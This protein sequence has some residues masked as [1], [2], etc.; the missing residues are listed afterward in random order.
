[1]IT[2]I[3]S[4][5]EN[6]LIGKS[7]GSMPWHEPEDLKWFKQTTMGFPIIMGRKTWE[8]LPK[9]PLPGR[10]NIVVS[11]SLPCQELGDHAFVPSIELA[12]G[13]AWVKSKNWPQAYDQIFVI[14]GAEIYKYVIEKNMVDEIIVSKIRGKHEGDIYFPKID[15]NIWSY[16]PFKRFD[17]FEV[18]KYMRM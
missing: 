18:L 14:G 4:T 15:E 11:R 17:N 16:M 1:M 7:D 13:L 2:I 5:D 3:V 6:W 9:K 10:Y 8:S 12:L